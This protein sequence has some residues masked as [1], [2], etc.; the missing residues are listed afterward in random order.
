M[1]YNKTC[2]HYKRVHTTRHK[3]T[4]TCSAHSKSAGKPDT[5]KNLCKGYVNLQ[6]YIR[7]ANKKICLELLNELGQSCL[8]RS[9]HETSSALYI[10]LLSWVTFLSTSII[11]SRVY[12]YNIKLGTLDM[13]K[14]KKVLHNKTFKLTP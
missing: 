1:Q 9:G 8:Q 11:S 3:H 6:L 2:Q 10:S 13:I 4:Y 5:L 12:M 14:E 7:K